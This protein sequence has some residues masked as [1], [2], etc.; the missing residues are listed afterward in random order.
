[1]IYRFPS[2][3]R[4]TFAAAAGFLLTVPLALVY[5][6]SACTTRHGQHAA[7]SAQEVSE[8]AALVAPTTP[9]TSK[10]EGILPHPAFAM[11]QATDPNSASA[12]IADIAE[13]V[14]PS[15]VNIS[16]ERVVKQQAMPFPF[17]FGPQEGGGAERKQQGSG[18][19]V[20]V[21]AD[22]IVLTN[23]HVVEEATEIKVTT[24]D[25]REFDAEVVGTD[26]KS[27][28]AV[29]RLKGPIEGLRPLAMGDSSRMRLGD[30]VLAIGNPFG[31]GQTV[32]MGIVSATGRADV[33]IV[34]YE[35]FIQT[36]AAINP[37]NS[38]GALVNMRGEL[39]GI[40]TAILS[41]SGG[42]QGVGF[43]IPTKMAQPVME[44]LITK[45]RVSRG[46][47]GVGIQDLTVELAAAMAVPLGTRGVLISEVQ[48]GG[49]A[50]KAGVAQGDIVLKV[51]GT[52]V[53]S[54]G[55]FRN[56]IGAKGGN[57]VANLD[58]L[59][60]GKAMV[61][62]VKL[63][64]LEDAPA[65]LK[66]SEAKDPA[67]LGLELAPLTEGLRKRLEM[68][69]KEPG[70]VV[71]SGVGRGSPSEEAG[72]RPGDVLLEVNRQPVKD[73]ATAQRLLKS[74]DK[75]VVLVRRGGGSRYVVLVR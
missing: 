63:A 64:E 71:V 73:V 44:S 24:F 40:N 3:P 55:R 18:S 5:W 54:S 21:A 62:Q 57:T 23:N 27:D 16:S 34:D 42:Y 70:S 50:A 31:V 41:R 67:T 11:A 49:A 15:V 69:D 2:K 13:R 22:G 9:T 29:L 7:Q 75:V 12:S 58:I 36:D 66:K 56:L 72:I 33:G 48:P 47:L 65:A 6:P 74:G 8:P 17:F 38:G 1:M 45:G 19:G 68:D 60:A 59:R 35:D 53:E 32:T 46:F 30:V 52:P 10:W 61:V 20:I 39:I 26:A 43:A 51:D 25:K 28:L 14:T 4:R 37:G